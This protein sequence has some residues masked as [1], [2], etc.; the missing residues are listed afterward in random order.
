MV[1]SKNKYSMGYRD[2][3]AVN[4]Y[5]LS[6]YLYKHH[7]KILSKLVKYANTMIFHCFIPASVQIGNNLDL[8][9]GGFG[10]VMH[11]D[12]VI[13][14]DAIIF[15]NVTIGNGGARI[16]DRVYIGTGATIIGA[17]IIGD[18][19]TI[20]ANTVVTF[21][22]PAGSTIVGVKARLITATDQQ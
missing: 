17:V 22:V 18:D 21:D 3:G 8:P 12:V 13:G 11:E 7:A 15:H 4:L 2:R 10:V 14:D 9:H 19:V 6:H 1:K 5:R 16:G 20:G